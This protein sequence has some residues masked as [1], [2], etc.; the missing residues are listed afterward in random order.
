MTNPRLLFSYLGDS[1]PQQPK[2]RC[3]R[4]RKSARFGSPKFGAGE[5]ELGL[6]ATTTRKIFCL[7]LLG[8]GSLGGSRLLARL[9]LP[10]CP[11]VGA[12]RLTAVRTSR[13]MRHCERPNAFLFSLSPNTFLRFIFRLLAW[14]IPPQDHKRI[15]RTARSIARTLRQRK[16]SSPK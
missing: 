16:R 10:S 4:P 15:R 13:P 1:K 7:S 6:A 2:L 8:K 11:R 5:L 3:T 14:P 12:Q 9:A